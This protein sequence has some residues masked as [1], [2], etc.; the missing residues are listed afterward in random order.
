MSEKV[1]LKALSAAGLNEPRVIEGRLPRD[2]HEVAVTQKYLDASGKKIGDTVTF[3]SAED[4]HGGTA[5]E[6]RCRRI[7][8]Y[9][10]D[11][12]ARPLHHHRIR[13]RSHGC[14]RRQ[15]DHEL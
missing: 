6:G 5:E 10:G 7:I 8:R 13:V 4:K 14:E 12:R 11:F 1:D 2:V 3:E 9:T 15:Q